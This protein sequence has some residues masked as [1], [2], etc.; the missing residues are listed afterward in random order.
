MLLKAPP[1]PFLVA[2]AK[3]QCKAIF[4][5][6]FEP[7]LQPLCACGFCTDGHYSFVSCVFHST[8]PK[9]FSLCL[10]SLC[11]I[12]GLSLYLGLQTMPL[13]RLGHCPT[14]HWERLIT[15]TNKIRVPGLC[16]NISWPLKWC[17]KEFDLQAVFDWLFCVSA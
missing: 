6:I 1:E 4:N 11:L 10:L 17:H 9:S 13:D 16:L 15:S 3:S 7:G 2:L 14:H 8:V 12:A 5:E